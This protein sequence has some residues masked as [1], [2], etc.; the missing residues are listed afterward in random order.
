MMSTVFGGILSAEL[1]GEAALITELSPRQK[2]F[3]SAL[4]LDER[5]FYDKEA[6]CVP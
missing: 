2:V 4:G 5:V 3:L 1:D 6:R